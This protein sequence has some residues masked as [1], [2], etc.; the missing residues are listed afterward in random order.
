MVAGALTVMVST[1]FMSLDD[2]FAMNSDSLP[3]VP[4]P[5]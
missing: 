3:P 1:N 5:R 4:C 2:I